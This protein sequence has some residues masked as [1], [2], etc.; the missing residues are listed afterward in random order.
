MQ[1]LQQIGSFN[2]HVWVRL[3][4]FLLPSILVIPAKKPQVKMIGVI[5]VK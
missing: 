3:Y 4:Q 5:T 1:D 2:C